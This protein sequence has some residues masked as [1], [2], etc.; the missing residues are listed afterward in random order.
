MNPQWHY[1]HLVIPLGISVILILA[2]IVQAMYHRRNPLAKPYIVFMVC[3]LIWML[4]SLLELVILNFRLSL[5][6]ADLSF[7]GISFF[8]V[9]WLGIALIYTG[10]EKIFRRFLPAF[11]VIPVLTTIIIWTNA[12][13]HLWRGE[14]TRD[15]TTT[16]FPITDYDYGPWFYFIHLPYGL[17]IA[18][19]SS[20]LLLR[21]LF[22][23]E[24][25]FRSQV[26]TLLIAFNLPL[27]ME[28]LHRIGFS[29]IPHFNMSTLVFPISG[30]LLGWS[31]LG[32]RFLEF[33]PI[34]RDLV[35]NNMHD[36]MIV[37]DNQGR[38]ADLNP[39][40]RQRLF[41]QKQTII[42]QRLADLFPDQ[43]EGIAQIAAINQPRFEFELQYPAEDGYIY[44]VL[45]S[46]I[47]RFTG[48][49]AGVLLLLRDITER[50]KAEFERE[51]LIADL[52]AYAHSVAHDLKNPL[53]ISV[54]FAS[55][56]LDEFDD[57][58]PTAQRELV[59]HILRINWKMTDIVNALLMLASVRQF[60]DI[61]TQP[62]AMESIVQEVVA[63]L[64]ATIDEAQAEVT[65]L[66]EEP[67]PIAMGYRPWLE[68]VWAN[69][70][71]N[72]LKY[73]GIPPRIEIGATTRDNG[74]VK[75]W[76]KDNGQGLTA[77]EQTRLFTQF[78]RL[79]ETR[80]EG[81]GIGLSIVKRIVEKLD[82]QVSVASIV[83][84]GSVF[85]FT[86]PMSDPAESNN[87]AL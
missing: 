40:S 87:H 46:P 63:R 54:G 60:S 82:G 3:I 86:L 38:V 76:V 8:S 9:T 36:L 35:I 67:W 25:V 47:Q 10:K 53:S 12:W 20:F 44:E 15:L 83:G 2:L 26:I 16:W 85:G 42:G 31:L 72:A 19:L 59:E 74:M 48:H 75:F 32:F 80:A 56:L 50:K 14:A 27:L 24:K 37:L 49:S 61:P 55:L 28:I 29:P 81:H 77:E 68:E 21:S 62:L 66:A 41:K 5:F 84:E 18:F 43:A 52:N 6:I 73:G 39:A 13:H 45:V 58:T 69:Y 51:Q 30:L 1:N 65:I 64:A 17:G 34:A 70:I 4:T 78:T 71:S 23:R 7:L 11:L 33:T 57:A 22:Y 79:D